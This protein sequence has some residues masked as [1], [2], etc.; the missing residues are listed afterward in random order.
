M[1]IGSRALH[2]SD[3]LQSNSTCN[4]YTRTPRTSTTT[5][6]SQFPSRAV[7]INP[8]TTT[9]TSPPVPTSN[10]RT[11]PRHQLTI[12]S[13]IP[14]AFL[15]PAAPTPILAA[16]LKP[17]FSITIT[18]TTFVATLDCRSPCGWR[19][20]IG[21]TYRMITDM[22][23]TAGVNANGPQAYRNRVRVKI[24]VRIKTKG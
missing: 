9:H 15:S 14:V 22:H 2:D 16:P 3:L 18:I 5:I 24:R 8:S 7:P 23:I 20:D 10:T 13:A 12:Q 19:A 21:K 11:S 6:L 1:S 4:A 17:M